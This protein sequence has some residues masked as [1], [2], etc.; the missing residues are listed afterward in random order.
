MSASQPTLPAPELASQMN[1]DGSTQL[2]QITDKGGSKP[3]LFPLLDILNHKPRTKITWQAGNGAVSFI[4]EENLEEGVEVFNNYG[5]KPN[6]QCL[7]PFIF[8]QPIRANFHEIVLL[9]YGFA[10]RDNPDDTVMLKLKPQLN[11]IQQ[12]IRDQQ[13]LAKDDSGIYHLKV[14]ASSPPTQLVQLF[15]ILVANQRELKLL[16][17]APAQPLKG[18]NE[19][20]AK[21][22]ILNSLMMKLEGSLRISPSLDEAEPRISHFAAYCTDFRKGQIKILQ[23]VIAKFEDEVNEL[24]SQSDLYSFEDLT[25]PYRRFRKAIA[26]CFG[27]IKDRGPGMDGVV[28]ILAICNFLLK[29]QVDESALGHQLGRLLED[30]P[31][32]LQGDED[33][34]AR[35]R[36]LYDDIFPAAATVAPKVFDGDRWTIQ[37]LRWGTRVY[38]GEVIKL[39]G[40]QEYLVL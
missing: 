27:D 6:Q 5:P 39:L 1:D 32:D 18:R 20:T 19:I 8:L 17:G 12:A 15:R 11:P 36:D 26:S 37:L 14:D 3:A 23:S 40:D 13:I 4:A 22:K 30:Y 29:N 33:E 25:Q 35:V 10:I 2:L 38:Q 31:M 24:C 9:S 16:M 34:E 28:F 7:C 21:V